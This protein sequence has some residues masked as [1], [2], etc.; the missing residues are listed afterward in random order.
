MSG[1]WDI[2]KR[3]R[4][5]CFKKRKKNKKRKEKKK[6]MAH[7]PFRGMNLE[8]TLITISKM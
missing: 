6:K 2:I 5:T 3:F 1:N 4:V 7:V 8:G